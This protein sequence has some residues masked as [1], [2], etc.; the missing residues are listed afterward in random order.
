M[1]PTLTIAKRELRANFD[2]PVPYVVLCLG[3]P[4]LAAFFFFYGGG[5]WQANRASME[6]LIMLTARGVAI[7]ASVL[8]MRV[9][10]EERRSGTL[11]ML[12]TLPVKDYQVVLGKF[13]GTWAV[14][15]AA[16]AVTLLFPIMMFKWPWQLGPLDWG[17]VRAGYLG[18]V[19]SSAA[20]VSLGLLISSLTESQVIAFF[21]TFAL[22][23]LLFVSGMAIDS[24]D[25][26][27]AR[28]VIAFISFDARL[29][30]LA[31]GLVTTRDVLYFISIAVICL[32]AS[33]S[34][35]ERRKWA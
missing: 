6:S 3:L 13:L 9:M 31:R 30:S 4:I 35:L 22:T 27:K 1:S 8:T 10:A 7:L 2:T 12:I 5:F 16:V 25:N 15:L 26:E 29:S 20:T 34:A 11:E 23:A 24:V 14:V 33:F 28:L 21:V 32:M 17:P 18:I 19:L